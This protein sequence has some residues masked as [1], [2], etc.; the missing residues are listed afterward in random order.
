ML[1]VPQQRRLLLRC[2]HID[3]IMFQVLSNVTQV[4]QNQYD[5]FWQETY[6]ISEYQFFNSNQ[7]FI[8]FMSF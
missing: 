6:A 5:F 4:L 1:I 3:I 8:D 2:H 7:L